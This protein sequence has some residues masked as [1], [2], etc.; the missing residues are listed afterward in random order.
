MSTGI[1]PDLRAIGD[2]FVTKRAERPFGRYTPRSPAARKIAA[3]LDVADIRING[4]RP[5]DM[6]VHDERLFERLLAEGSLAAGESY[7]DG[8]WDVEAMDELFTRIHRAELQKHVGIAGMMWLALKGRIFNRQTRSRSLAVAQEHYDLGNDLYEA[9]LDRRMQ[10][11][12]AY[13]K[14]A[15]TLDQA[16][17]NKL[18]LICRKLDLKPGM[19]VLELGGGFGGLAHFAATEYGCHIVSYN[20]SREQVAYAREW[21]R[22][23]PVRFEEKD[24]REAANEPEQ[25]DRVASIGLCEHV[26]YKNYRR[27]L[28]LAH[29]RLK[30]G[31]LFLL[32]TI[33]ANRSE[34]STDPWIDR[35]IF[36]HGMLPSTAQLSAAMEDL[37]LVEDWHNF[38]PDYDPTLMAWW[39]N[40]DRAW[41]RLRERYSDRFYRMW[42]YYIHASA[43]GFRARKMQLWQLALSK[44]DIASYAPVR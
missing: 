13:W 17:E 29:D 28:E 35:Y 1:G 33:G 7:M 4:T 41:P 16:Q 43:G 21:C 37:W 40:F 8:W 38:G 22:G 10:Y 42:K 3:L 14:N 34:T 23:L 32:H 30:P 9:M 26:G 20:I 6:Q 36:P 18:H 2:V 5:W 15:S 31:G 12:C 27:F 44:G 11:T 24:Y 25:F 19:T 39:R